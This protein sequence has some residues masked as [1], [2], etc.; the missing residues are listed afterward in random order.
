MPTAPERAPGFTTW[1][2]FSALC[3]SM[4]MAILDIQIVSTSL[5]EIQGAIAIQPADMSWIQ[6]AYL[7]A[8]VIAIALTGRLTNA[9]GLARLSIGAT[10]GFALASA[11]CAA[12]SGFA[13]LIGCRILQGLAGG[14]LIPMVFSAVFLLFDKK[15]QG[16][17]TGIAGSLAVLAPAIG[18]LIGG[19]ITDS[20]SWHWLF[21]IN[22]GPAILAIL[23]VHQCLP[24]QAMRWLEMRRLDGIGLL[25]LVVTLASLEIALKEAPQRGWL[26]L[27]MLALWML[28][29]IAGG[30][31]C[32][33]NWRAT[34]PI[35]KLHLLRR[36]DFAIGC[37]LSFLLGLGLFGASY[38]LPVFLG[39]VRLHSAF[40][41]GQVMLV[42]GATQL[43]VA[44][45]AVWLERQGHHRFLQPRWLS[46]LGFTSLS[47][48]LLLSAFAT[49]ESD[50]DALFW[51]QVLRGVA[52][53]FCLLPPTRLAL[54]QLPAALVA[55]GSAL[56]NLM[57]NL[58]GALGLAVIDTIIWQRAP[59][60]A[61]HIA[62]RLLAGDATA[63]TLV[64]L[65]T[66]RFHG[67]PIP[68]PDQATQDMLRPL[69]ERAGL[70]IAVNEAWITIGVATLLGAAL[71]LYP[72]RAR[73]IDIFSRV[74]PPDS[75]TTRANGLQQK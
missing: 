39:Y 33:R 75:S 34:D 27:P 1:L 10:A 36:A 65:D 61:T 67:V 26:T 29:I 2:G 46:L 55:D 62:T 7:T 68:M 31:F 42:T 49:F 48:G 60:E 32:R 15:H 69:I 37:A 51:P 50:F 70:V 71:A 12:S 56:F 52:I 4:F 64:G 23:A 40:E 57:R 66:D 54:D 43:A 72:W 74:A 47:C 58:G 38:L 53:M 24:R 5:P 22:I 11:G 35:A 19:W 44:P 6:T 25:A 13:S 45:I 3:I 21:L 73:K 30:F 59:I 8:E 41:I 17:A 14:C 18:P 9:C 63:A 16:L 28:V 20:Y